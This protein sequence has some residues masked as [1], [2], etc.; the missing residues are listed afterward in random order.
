MI[1][2]TLQ[3]WDMRLGSYGHIHILESHKENHHS[4]TAESTEKNAVAD[5]L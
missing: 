3:E 1:L 4:V 2:K 5:R